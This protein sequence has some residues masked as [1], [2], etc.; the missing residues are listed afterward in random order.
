MKEAFSKLLKFQCS[1]GFRFALNTCFWIENLWRC[2]KHPT[3][4]HKTG[5]VDQWQNF[6]FR[7]EPHQLSHYNPSNHSSLYK[8]AAIDNQK[9]LDIYGQQKTTLVRRISGA[10]SVSNSHLLSRLWTSWQW[11][12]RTNGNANW[13]YDNLLN[14]RHWIVSKIHLPRHS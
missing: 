5:R 6:Y 2:M 12:K 7:C 1:C 13:K 8:W 9:T 10:W 4:T 11:S 3:N 14:K